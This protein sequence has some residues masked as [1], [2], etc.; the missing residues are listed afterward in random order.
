MSASRMKLTFLLWIPTQ[1]A[2]SASCVLRPGRNPYEMPRNS[3]SWIAFSS[4]TTARWT[5]LSSR[6]A[7]A[8]GRC[9]P[10]GL[11]M[12]TRRL[13]RA[14][15]APLWTRLCKIFEIALELCLVVLPHQPVHSRCRVHLELVERLREEIDADVV[16]ERNKL[17]LLPFPCDFPYAVQRAWFACAQG[18]VCWSAF[19]L[20][21][22]LGSPGSAANA[23]AADCS[24]AGCTALFAGFTATMTES[25]FSCPCIIGY[26]SSPSR[27]G[28]SLSRNSRRPDARPPSFRCDPFARDVAFDPGRAPAP[29]I[30]V[31]HMLPSSE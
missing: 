11:G 7:T 22:A 21:S 25:D 23:S 1:S 24:A 9:R 20:V 10:S 15:Y 13:G 4:A 8:S 14:R 5:I 16:E 28:P 31:P 19:P 27:C 17:L 26:G 29:R 30:A 2:S 12:Y 3:S 18:M 6:A